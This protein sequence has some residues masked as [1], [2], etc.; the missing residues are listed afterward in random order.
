MT[1]PARSENDPKT[2]LGGHGL[3]DL[4]RTDG[5]KTNPLYDPVKAVALIS[6]SLV[7]YARP[8][9]RCIP[10]QKVRGIS[11]IARSEEKI[12]L[13]GMHELAL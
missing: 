6:G 8:L 9:S 7:C 11:T 10:L 13:S 5:F 12:I 4:L 3:I 2:D 1:P